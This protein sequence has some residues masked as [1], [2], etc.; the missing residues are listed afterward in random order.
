M[1][2]WQVAQLALSMVLPMRPDEATGLLV[3]DVDVEKRTLRFGTR[4]SGAD[5]TKG[6]QSFSL[7]FPQEFDPILRVRWS[8]WRRAPAPTPLSFPGERRFGCLLVRRIVSAF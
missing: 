8:S 5:F 7:P 1:D 3:S 4:L 6:R 2:R